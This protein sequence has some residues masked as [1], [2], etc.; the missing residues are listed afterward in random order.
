MVNQSV[1]EYEGNLP[2]SRERQRIVNESGR[3]AVMFDVTSDS[4]K[5]Q[6]WDVIDKTWTAP[7]ERDT[8]MNH[9]LRKLVYTC[10]VCTETSL[11]EDDIKRHIAQVKTAYEMCADAELVRGIG[12]HGQPSFTCSGCGA[13]MS[14]RKNQ[15]QRHIDGIK[16][17]YDAHMEAGDVDIQHHLRCQCHNKVLQQ[18]I[19]VAK[20][21]SYNRRV[22]TQSKLYVNLASVEGEDDD[23]KGSRNNKRRPLGLLFRR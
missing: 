22:G 21:L 7:L 16:N 8:A 10:S 4:N 15:G 2:S 18:Y 5:I 19:L 1:K 11:F 9:Y 20:K 17:R 3:D 23:N 13:P 12:E 14:M 6:L